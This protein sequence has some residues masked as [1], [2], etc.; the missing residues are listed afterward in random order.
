M[1]Y[2]DT[3]GRGARGGRAIAARPPTAYETASPGPRY[4][5]PPGIA[6]RSRTIGV[7]TA[8]RDPRAENPGPGSY[9][10]APEAPRPPP[11]VGI[12]GPAPEERCL[13]GRGGPAETPGPAYYDA[14]DYFAPGKYKGFTLKHRPNTDVRAD[15]A[16]PY[17]ACRSTL[18][19]PKFTIGLRGV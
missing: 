10:L 15:S 6:P 13:V 8:Q 7:R 9:W 4:A 11:V 19:G 1:P 5:L 2:Y 17:H 16:P 14:V 18:G 3:R 12:L